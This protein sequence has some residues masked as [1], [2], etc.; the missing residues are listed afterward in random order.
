VE[1][2]GADNVHLT[3]LGDVSITDNGVDHSGGARL[4][5]FLDQMR[6]NVEA[7]IAYRRGTTPDRALARLVN[8]RDELV[9]LSDRVSGASPSRRVSRLSDALREIHLDVVDRQSRMYSREEGT[10]TSSIEDAVRA[11]AA[12]A[13]ARCDRLSRALSDAAKTAES[14]ALHFVN[15]PQLRGGGRLAAEAR[16]VADRLRDERLSVAT[17]EV[18]RGEGL[19]AEMLNLSDVARP[20]L[21]EERALARAAQAQA[22]A[23]EARRQATV[24]LGQAISDLEDSLTKVGTVRDRLRYNSHAYQQRAELDSKISE[25]QSTLDDLKGTLRRLGNG[26][27]ALTAEEELLGAR[28]QGG[29]VR[30]ALEAGGRR[31]NGVERLPSGVY[32]TE[33]RAGNSVRSSEAVRRDAELTVQRAEAAAQAAERRTQSAANA[34]RAAQQTAE[35]AEAAAN[36]AERVAQTAEATARNAELAAQRA[37]QVAREMQLRT[38]PEG[39]FVVP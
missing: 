9:T 36:A 6:D 30:D 10:S 32:D 14:N 8:D 15:E 11:E 26:R 27:M 7:E 12:A 3:A 22:T 19:L 28:G 35:R 23:R 4:G 29:R 5:T 34:A 38:F 13:R 17:A 1:H 37:E 31:S 25:L 24:R 2:V 39:R 16:F 21:E 18:K 20:L 33:S